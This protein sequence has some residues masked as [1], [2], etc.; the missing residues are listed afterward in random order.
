MRTEERYLSAKEIYKKLEIDTDQVLKSLQTVPI[1]MHCWQGDDVT[2]FEGAGAL[3]GGIQATGNYP[4][5]ARNSEELM[6]D[7]DKALS[8][9]PGKHR[10]N[11]HASYAI[12]EDGE[13]ADR[14]KLEPK[15]FAKWVAFAKCRGL[16]I[17][18]NPTFFSHPKA[19]SG[20][21]LSHPEQV[22]REFWVNH[23]KACLKISEYI[24]KE[25][26][27]PCLMNIWIP[28]GYKIFLRIGLHQENV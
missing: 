16:G 14:D 9:I 20:L 6:A 24:G 13:K 7:I 12:F 27:T 1:S 3:T 28:D 10:I 4:G 22:I 26:N 8:L 2:G 19:S 25:L 11:L 15:H 18:F 5:K 21:T 23:G 17:D